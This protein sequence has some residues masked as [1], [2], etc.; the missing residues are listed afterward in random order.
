VL[1]IALLAG[2]LD[3]GRGQPVVEG[4]RLEFRLPD[5]E[6]NQ[7]GSDDP[8]FRDSVV[9]VTAW[10]TWC[11]PCISEIP[12]LVD[13]QFRLGDEGLVVV[14]IAFEHDDGGGERRE[15]LRAFVEEHGINYLVLDGGRPEDFTLALPAVDNVHGLPVEFV[16]DRQGRVVDAR[17]SRGYR[18][19]WARKLEQELLGLLG[20]GAGERGGR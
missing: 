5:L 20:P 16:I 2:P 12:T 7:V 15:R 10:G 1:L 18:K 3:A 13:L 9:F 6:G 19:R 14:A 8:R 11:P 17:N 4:G